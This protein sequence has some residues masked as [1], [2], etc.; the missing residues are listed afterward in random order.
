[1]AHVL[2]V[3]DDEANR[4]SLRFVLEDAGHQVR[5]AA[6][7][8]EALAVLRA[9]P[10]GL[11][12][13]LD[14]LMP[15]VVDG[16]GVLRAAAAD[17]DLAARHAWV[18][19]TAAS[20][21]ELAAA[22][23]P[24]AEVGA[25]VVRKPFDIDELLV[26]VASAAERAGAR[27]RDNMPETGRGAGVGILVVDDEPTLQE[28]LQDL[29]ELEGY[30]VRRA[31]NGV[32]ALEQVE[33]ERPQLIV[34]DLMMPRM[35]GYEFV[36]ELERRNLR[37]QLPIIIL[38]ADGRAREKAARVGAEVGIAKPFDVAVLLGEVA[39]LV[40]PQEHP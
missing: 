10:E 26:A 3:D 19:V 7:G 28:A 21:R 31:G 11:V 37:S 2:V 29:L 32:E 23:G 39:R 33:A 24:A 1:M 15:G 4:E 14:L 13:L 38:T 8:G 30:A 9:A 34:L 5:E 12:V 18:V 40:Q 27:G 17:A 20:E 16:L 35:N 25:L 22:S 6:T 36:A